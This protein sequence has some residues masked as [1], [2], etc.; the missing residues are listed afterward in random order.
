MAGVLNRISIMTVRVWCIGRA[1]DGDDTPPYSWSYGDV[2]FEIKLPK[3]L[4]SGS[5]SDI[6]DNGETSFRGE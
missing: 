3:I 5:G 1:P 4:G 2:G 6:G